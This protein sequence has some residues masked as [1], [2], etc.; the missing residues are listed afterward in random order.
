[1][2]RKKKEKKPDSIQKNRKL[3]LLLICLAS[4]VAFSSNFNGEILNFDDNLYFED[5]DITNLT[6]L[7][8]A[9]YF[10]KHYVIMY[11]PLPILSFAVQYNLHE[12]NPLP[13]HLFNFIFHLLN[14]LLV[15]V[16]AKALSHKTLVGLLTALVFAVHPMNTEAVS[17]ISARSSVMYSFFF[18]ASLYVY[19][20]YITNVKKH[21]AKWFIFA[22][23]LA[24]L[25]FFS[26]A[27]ALPLPFVLVLL[28]WYAKRKFNPKLILE[29]I[30]FIALSVIFGLV[31][32]SDS[33]TANNLNIG[34]NEFTFFQGLLLSFYTL[35]NYVVQFFAPIHLAAIHTYP[36]KTITGGLPILYYIAP[37]VLA[38]LA[39]LVFKFK[40]NRNLIFSLLFFG[41]IV[42]VTLQIIPSRLFM[43]ADRYVYLPYVGF[44]FFIAQF[45][46]SCASSKNQKIKKRGS[47]FINIVLVWALL[48]A[49]I[50]FNRNKV[51]NNTETLVT[52]I[53]EKNNEH[54]Y[55]S[56][57]YGIRAAIKESRKDSR[58]ALA[59]LNKAVEIRG[60]EGEIFYNRGQVHFR[61][62]NYAKALSD[63]IKAREIMGNHYQLANFMAGCEYNL[64]RYVSA[65]E[66]Y[67]EAIE[68]KPDYAEAIRNRGSVYASIL[69]YNNAIKDYS[70]AIEL[71]PSDADAF[72]FRGFVYL[73]LNNR[74]K[75]CND[76]L[77]AKQLGA[78]GVEPSIVA[79]KCTN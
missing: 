29:K 70:K 26:K 32:I 77:R 76:L 25:S 2:G 1:M 23:G 39:V 15:Y 52:D 36:V 40:N 28:D 12:L 18:L 13:Y 37:M 43:M 69:E 47:I 19:W 6:W 34:T 74:E 63:F 24:L 53:I 51:W 22:F 54:P 42:S 10:T 44:A 56:R 7:N 55:L 75:A 49:I 45:I 73:K 35:G 8:L 64:N 48:L 17:W 62:T 30:P 21:N 31:A 33:G 38:A 27:N 79:N 68:L 20:Q 9:N 16:F 4:A 5:T 41:I 60:T 3:L 57:A 78:Q 11:H 72:K 58:G 71:V 14:I 46:N 61:M 67:N 65:L 50:S 59:D 66:Y